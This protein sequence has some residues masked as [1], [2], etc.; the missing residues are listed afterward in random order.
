MQMQD[1]DFEHVKWQKQELSENIKEE[2]LTEKG[3]P[4]KKMVVNNKNFLNTA[5]ALFKLEIP[6]GILHASENAYPAEDSKGTLDC[7]YEVMRRKNRR[8]E[9]NFALRLSI[10]PIRERSLDDLIQELN[11][12]LQNLKCPITKEGG[13]YDTAEMLHK[14]LARDIQNCNPDINCMWDLGWTMMLFADAEKDEVVRDVEKHILNML[15]NE[16]A[17]D[18]LNLNITV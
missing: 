12:D 2:S 3:S 14:M 15:I 10:A 11:G 17:L 7:V 18:I 8:E 5:Q 16:F 13:N 6:I 9:S 1:T 4:F